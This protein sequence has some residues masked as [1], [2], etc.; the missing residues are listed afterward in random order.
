MIKTLHPLIVGFFNV[1]AIIV[2]QIIEWQ[3]IEMEPLPEAGIWTPCLSVKNEYIVIEPLM[4]EYTPFNQWV[5]KCLLVGYLL[6]GLRVSPFSLDKF[7]VTLITRPWCTWMWTKDP[8]FPRPNL[9]L[10]S[11]TYVCIHVSNMDYTKP[12]ML[13]LILVTL[14]WFWTHIEGK[15]QQ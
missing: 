1:V 4:S 6:Y 14:W 10:L 15:W 7:Y 5:I 12:L 2:E 3:V 8:S 11:F 9:W 13:P